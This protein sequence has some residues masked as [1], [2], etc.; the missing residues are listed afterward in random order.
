ALIAGLGATLWSLQ[1]A[2][3]D[4]QRAQVT[5]DFMSSVLSSVDPG[6]AQGLDKTLML[7]A[8]RIA[9]S[10]LQRPQRCAQAG[11]QR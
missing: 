11:N 9:R 3:R 2:A 6:T 10:M 8:L 4:A 1:H 5:G 7:R